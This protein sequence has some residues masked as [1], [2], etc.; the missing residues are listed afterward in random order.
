MKILLAV[1]SSSAAASVEGLLRRTWPEGSEARIV[2]V[3][4]A[5]PLVTDPVLVIAASHVET[6]KQEQ[7]RAARAVAGAA[8]QIAK[9]A[10]ALK[11]STQILEGS[12]KKLIV[13][14]AERWG[15]DLI[16][17]GSHH[18]EPGGDFRIGSVA[19]AVAETAPCS[20]E[21]ARPPRAAAA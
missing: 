7:Q 17:V 3:V 1:K 8:E 11:V 9:A 16:L 15:A 4:H 5:S 13:E 14:E 21:I 18:K 10:P 6:R 20:V 12:P 2:S 19:Q